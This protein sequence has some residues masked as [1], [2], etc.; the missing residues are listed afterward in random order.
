MTRSVKCPLCENIGT[1]RYFGVYICQKH[2]E[3]LTGIKP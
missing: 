1:I 2:W 3:E